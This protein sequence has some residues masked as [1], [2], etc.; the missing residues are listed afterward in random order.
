VHAHPL[1]TISTITYKV[2]VYLQLRGQIHSPYIQS[3]L[4]CT[5]QYKG[6]RT[7]CL[8]QDIEHKLTLDAYPNYHGWSHFLT[9]HVFIRPLLCCTTCAQLV[10]MSFWLPLYYLERPCTVFLWNCPLSIID[11]HC[12]AVAVIC[13]EQR[14]LT[15]RLD[16]IVCQKMQKNME[17]KMGQILVKREKISSVRYT[18]HCTSGCPP[19]RS[20]ESVTPNSIHFTWRYNVLYSTLYLGVQCTVHCTCG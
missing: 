10:H 13:S 7:S 8:T 3:T 4:V 20:E 1:K 5:L 11:K 2:V 15:D 16:C 9:G 14:E 18:I 6:T 12:A 17:K 19:P